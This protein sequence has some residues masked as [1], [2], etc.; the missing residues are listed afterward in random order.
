MI[1]TIVLTPL[2]LQM[3]G[4][5]DGVLSVTYRLYT[6]RTYSKY[7]TFFLNTIIARFL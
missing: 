7:S 3:R 2:S 5:S 1:V 4:E 6:S